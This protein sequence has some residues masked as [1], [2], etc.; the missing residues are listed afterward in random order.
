MLVIL[1][2][3]VIFLAFSLQLKG[4]PDLPAASAKKLRKELTDFYAEKQITLIALNLES[5]EITDNEILNANGRWNAVSVGGKILGYCVTGEAWGRYEPF[6]YAAIFETNLHLARLVILEYRS[7]Q[8]KNVTDPSWLSK[9]SRFTPDSLPAYGKNIDAVSGASYS[10]KGLT[11]ALA[12]DLILL[13]KLDARGLLIP[14]GLNPTE[15][16]H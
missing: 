6:S 7:R 11:E 8:G 4:Q 1:N 10:G 16:N 13:K 9:F 14:L 12:S 2:F 15:S 5:S 3:L